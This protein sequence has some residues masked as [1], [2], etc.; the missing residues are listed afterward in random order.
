MRATVLI[1]AIFAMLAGCSVPSVQQSVLVTVAHQRANIDRV[2]ALRA[3]YQDDDGPQ[4][5]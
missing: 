4:I 2:A 1:A 5:N 3:Q